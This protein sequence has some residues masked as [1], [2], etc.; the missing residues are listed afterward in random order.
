MTHASYIVDEHSYYSTRFQEATK[1]LQQYPALRDVF[2]TVSWPANKRHRA[3]PLVLELAKEQRSQKTVPLLSS[4]EGALDSLTQKLNSGEKADLYSELRS[5]DR[6][7]VMSRMLELVCYQYFASQGLPVTPEPPVSNGGVTDLLVDDTDPVYVEITRLGTSDTELDIEDMYQ[8]VGKQLAADIPRN[9]YL[10]LDVDSSKLDWTGTPLDKHGSE[11]KILQQVRRSQIL[12]LL[13]HRDAVPLRDI[14]SMPSDWTLR[15]VI[16]DSV[17]YGTHGT[18]GENWEGIL[19][20]PQFVPALQTRVEAFEGP[21]ITAMMGGATGGLVELHSDM[22]SPSSA[23]NSQ[24]SRFLNRV[25]RK[26]EKKLR[27]GQREPGEVN[28]LCIGATHWLA[29]GYTKSDT[30]PPGRDQRAKL[31]T[32][33]HDTLAQHS[34]PEL[35][36]VVLMEDDPEQSLWVANPSAASDLVTAYEETTVAHILG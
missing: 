9:T 7:K 11:T 14:Q 34:V 36:G 29:R 22:F 25:E 20:D 16:E 24:E 31:T 15:E 13:Q 35:V 19:D 28:V 6:R 4:V 21:V 2:G 30:H 8:S 32:A 23:A 12:T 18:F 3:N 1:R 10:R 17:R 26:V 5:S 33:I 27:K